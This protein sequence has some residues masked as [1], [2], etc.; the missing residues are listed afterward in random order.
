MKKKICLVTGATSGIGLETAKQLARLGA[1]VIVVGRNATKCAS[2]VAR[3]RQQTGNAQVE[4]IVADLSAQAQVRA[5]A[6]QFQRR[7]ARL[8]VLVNNVGAFIARRRVSADGIEMTFALNHLAPFLLTNLLRDVLIASAPARIVN[9]SSA[10]HAQGK[11]VFD[12]LQMARGYNGLAQYNNSKLANVL[13]TYE[14]ARRLAGTRVTVNALHPGAVR[15]NL[16]AANGGVFKWIVQPL[17]NLIAISVEEGART[18][19]YLAS[20]PEVEGVTGKYFGKCKEWK[21]SPASY[22]EEAQKKLWEV[23]AAMMQ[24]IAIPESTQ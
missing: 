1:T 19:V 11:I 10:L 16:T 12:D 2:V 14:L 21:S 15:T 8:D 22:D 24:Q 13:F 3:I 5:L 18:N 9:V 4:S 17:F 7:Y 6:E 20:S 23:S